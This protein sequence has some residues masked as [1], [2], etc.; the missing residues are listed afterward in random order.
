MASQQKLSTKLVPWSTYSARLGPSRPPAAGLAHLACIETT[1]HPET[2]LGPV[3]TLSQLAAQLGVTVQ[4]LYDLRS[5][6]RG[7]RGFRVGRAAAASVPMPRAITVAPVRR[8]QRRLMPPPASPAIWRKSRNVR[9]TLYGLSRPPLRLARMVRVW[10][11]LGMVAIRR[12][13]TAAA[14]SGTGM[15]RTD[16]SVFG[17]GWRSAPL[18][19]RCTTVPL[20]L[21]IM[22][23][24]ISSM[25]QGRRASTS[26]AAWRFRAGPR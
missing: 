7:P 2:A 13:S 19:L 15:R 8:Y 20:T 25:S 4:T 21:A 26:R 11:L 22:P 10:A 16:A 3:L 17:R 18:P 23:V 1:T 9:R 5:Q 24:G 14:N 6:G 12:R